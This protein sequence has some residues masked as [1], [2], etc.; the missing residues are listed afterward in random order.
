MRF[1]KT[2]F[3]PVVL[4]TVWSTGLIATTLRAQTVR[5]NPLELVAGAVD[6]QASA[7]SNLTNAKAFNEFAKATGQMAESLEQVVD[8]DMK[9][10]RAYWQKKQER[11]AIDRKLVEQKIENRTLSEARRRAQV[12]QRWDALYANP[13]SYM[14]SAHNGEALNFMLEQLAVHTTLAYSP[15]LP[16]GVALTVAENYRPSSQCIEAIR[17]TVPSSIGGNVS[18]KLTEPIPLDLSWWPHLLMGAEFDEHRTLLTQLRIGLA[19]AVRDKRAFSHAEVT[20]IETA[21]AA[22]TS[23][24]FRQYPPTQRKGLS[25][26]EYHKIFQAED[27]LRQLDQ[28]VS[29]V[30]F[31]GTSAAFQGDAFRLDRDGTH[32][33]ALLHYMLKNNLRFAP[34]RPAE[35]PHYVTLTHMAKGF[36]TLADVSPDKQWI[37]ASQIDVNLQLDQVPKVDELE[38]ET[39]LDR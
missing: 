17:V 12:A 14:I 1:M 38:K 29:R 10:F 33:G 21:M 11:L 24:F 18:M 36:C 13:A 4:L 5:R 31:A 27:Y 19:G 8:L 20:E 26:R 28:D 2:I 30:V 32:L 34:A 6:Q 35:E 9:T 23:A 37:E 25:S 16:S 7:N 15:D 22:L 39:D 3:G